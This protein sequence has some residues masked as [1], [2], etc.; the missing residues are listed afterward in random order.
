VTATEERCCFHVC[1]A[2]EIGQLSK[3]CS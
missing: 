3:E 2:E 1:Q